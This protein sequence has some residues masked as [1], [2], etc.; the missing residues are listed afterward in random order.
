MKVLASSLL[1]AAMAAVVRADTCDTASV[2]ALLTSTEVT[3]C[4]SASGYSPSS[5]TTPTSAEIKTMCSNTA[6]QEVLSDLTTM[7]PTECTVGTFALY[8]DLITPV[9]TGC[10]G[11]SSSSTAASAG[12]SN[13][14]TSASASTAAS[15]T[16]EAASAGSAD[17]VA[18]TSSASLDSAEVVTVAPTTNSSASTDSD[19]TVGDSTSG[20]D[21]NIETQAPSSQSA[22]TTAD[23][24]ASASSAADGT[25]S[26]SSAGV[27]V[28]PS[29]ALLGSALVA[30]AALFL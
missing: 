13:A 12:G 26:G 1:A 28:S 20:S 30:T 25:S 2:T 19:V 22:S 7:F 10:S 14:S 8:A 17:A 23:S 3:T 21:L 5:L 29:A 9:T 6:C 11:S 27:A 16:S 24:A 4:A 15:T 18:S